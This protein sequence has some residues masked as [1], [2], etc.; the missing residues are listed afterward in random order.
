M[1]AQLTAEALL[2]RLVALPPG[3]RDAE[4]ER[5]LGI[6]VREDLSR[7]P[8][9]ELIG[10]HPSGVAPVLC[11]LVEAGVEEDDLFVDLGC[12]LGKVAV[13]ARLLC[14]ARVRGIEVQRELLDRSPRVDGVELVHADV[15]HAPLEDGTVFFLYNPF[16][17][18]ALRAVLARLQ[19]VARHH[20]I[21]VCA[22]G[23][24]LEHL[25]Q[26]W[27]TPRPTEHFWLR[28]FDSVI[29]GVPAR[30]VRARPSDP[31]VRQLAMER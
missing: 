8:G 6:D 13:L 9:P 26:S 29:P 14:G 27:L 10:Y 7:S 1:P 4:L 23:V 16:T 22:L 20:A 19:A 11:A 21:V 24:E 31:R 2:S 28:V 17:G 12:G 30:V 3:Q 15:R 25:A 18:D 5:L